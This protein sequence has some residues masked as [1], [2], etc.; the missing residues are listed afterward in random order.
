A[1]IVEVEGEFSATDA[2]QLCDREGL[3][4]GRGLVNYSNA[5]IEQ[6]K[7]HH[8]AEIASI[9]GYDSADTVV[10]RNNLAFNI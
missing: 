2:V 7:G 5:E 8:S 4:L 1:G 9:L 10:H 6:I 3:E